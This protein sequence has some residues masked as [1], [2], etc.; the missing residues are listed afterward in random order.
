M[1]SKRS[2]AKGGKKVRRITPS[3]QDR[4]VRT[5]ADY[6]VDERGL[7]H[8]T[9][10]LERV[11]Y[12]NEDSGFTIADVVA[13]TTNEAITVTGTIPYPV[14]GETLSLYGRWVYHPQYGRQIKVETYERIAPSDE[15]AMLKYLKG[16]AVKGIG[17]KTA[18]R[19]VEMF[20]EDT[21]T[22][23]D[24]HPEW[25]ARIPGISLERAREIG[26]DYREKA[27]IR[28]AYLFFGNYFGNTL[29]VRIYKRF[30]SQA[31]ARAKENPYA[32]CDQVEGVTFEKADLMAAN[33]GMPHDSP[34]RV[35]SGILFL[36]RHNALKNGHV[37]L[38]RDK[39]ESA[40]AEMLGVSEEM[41]KTALAG[42]I[43]SEQVVEV[44]HGGRP[45]VYS[46]ELYEA[47]RSI[48][49]KLLLLDRCCMPV[50]AKNINAMIGREE[51][52]A[53]IRYGDM[54]RNAIS[55]AMSSGVMILT[56]GPGTGKTTVVRAMLEI[57]RNMRMKT[58]LIAPTGRAAKRL[59]E[60][61]HFE[62][63]TIHRQLE[64]QYVPDDEDDLAGTRARFQRD[65]NNYL[66]ESVIIVDETSMVDCLLMESLT[67][68][69]RPGSRLILIGD[70]DQLPSVGPGNVLR[71]LI[72][73]ELF[74][75]V[76]LTQ[77]FRQA[78]ESLI[79][80]NAHAI[81]DGQM[82][83]LDRRDSDFF[84]IRE[85]N[86]ERI[87]GLVSDLYSRR[88][89]DA[90]GEDTKGRM[91]IICP[92]RRGA[93]GT[94]SINRVIQ[95]LVNPAEEGKNEY[96]W[97]DLVYREGDRVMQIRN[98][99][100][101]EWRREDLC[102]GLGLFNGDIGE[103][104]SIDLEEGLMK[105][106]FDDRIVDY[107]FTDLED[108]EHAWA[109]TVHKSQGS[110]YPYVII[111]VGNSPPMLQTRNL[112]YTAVTRA[113]S[114]VIL[115]GKTATIRTMVDNNRQVLRYTGLKEQLAVCAQN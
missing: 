23:L 13:D 10:S 68:A 30:G 46:R 25:L 58:A 108:L 99:Y 24:D 95:E 32:L 21:F 60:A 22:V 71:D 82:P 90:Y 92:S 12:S 104:R 14:R 11:I 77:I 83:V 26:R 59:G 17:P 100:N 44:D 86:D 91:Q 78:S 16:N 106:C 27:G 76:K 41:T 54:Q 69:I 79:I 49:K 97:R 4:E 94:D 89:P 57:F 75:T 88:L 73:S 111:P 65:K 39:C 103:I 47:E 110:E 93:C 33:L 20:G 105:I 6:P 8:I 70:S 64:M 52:R 56:G 51:T 29:T 2:A 98:N 34:F 62:A 87:V 31:V 55:L 84:F 37:C 113:Q 19:I 74:A 114:M 66:D 85:E 15:T 109:I 81:N 112:L 48:A 72:E 36:L 40:A 101:I 35:N 61:T 96:R 63:S 43:E 53:G 107:R 7:V 18:E 115:V 5:E 38:P 42:L 9:G 80:T 67:E 28:T 45:I 50:D 102:V 1:S 3:R